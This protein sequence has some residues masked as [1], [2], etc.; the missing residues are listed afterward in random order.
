MLV[1]ERM[2]PTKLIITG[3]S[4]ELSIIEGVLKL[5]KSKKKINKEEWIDGDV[6]QRQILEYL[7]VP[8]GGLMLKHYRESQLLSH[9]DLANRLEITAEY[10]KN[11]ENGKETINRKLSKKL[12]LLFDIPAEIFLK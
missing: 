1:H 3:N 2:H 10:I 7:E 11:I 12:E 6:V 8:L 4:K 5:F 9:E